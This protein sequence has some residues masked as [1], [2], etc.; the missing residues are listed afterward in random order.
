MENSRRELERIKYG[1]HYIGNVI[2][3]IDNRTV[4]VNIGKPIL[5][6]GDT[7][8][9][10]EVG[11]L[12]KDIDGTDLDY[13]EYIKDTLEVTQVNDKYSIC[14]KTK[15][16][17]ISSLKALSPDNIFTTKEYIPL[18]VNKDDISPFTEIDNT[19]KIG[20]PIKLY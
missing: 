7:I 16:K 13:L 11:E 17:T 19:I 2:R 18:K 20:D 5:S 6:V 12:I 15:T 8:Q 14:T 10:Y 3:I 9:I 4:V 1:K